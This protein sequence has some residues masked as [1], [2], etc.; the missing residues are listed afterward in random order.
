MSILKG[1]LLCLLGLALLKVAWF[2]LFAVLVFATSLW[3]KFRRS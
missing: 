2:A 1:L 3:Q